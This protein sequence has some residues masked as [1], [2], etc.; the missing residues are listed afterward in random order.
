MSL[1][2]HY[3][4]GVP[5]PGVEAAWLTRTLADRETL[6]IVGPYFPSQPIIADDRTSPTKPSS[7]SVRRQRTSG[8]YALQSGDVDRAHFT[9]EPSHF[10]ASASPFPS[11]ASQ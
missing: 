6:L 1:V 8:P 7:I 9:D 10:L 3:L 4:L 5:I 2:P 11:G